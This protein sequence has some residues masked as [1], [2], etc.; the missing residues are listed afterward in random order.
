[1]FLPNLSVYLLIRKF[2]KFVL[3]SSLSKIALNVFI[4]NGGCPVLLSI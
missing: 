1:M 2:S 4:E 3:S